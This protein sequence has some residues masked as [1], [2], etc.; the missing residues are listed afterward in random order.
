MAFKHRTEQG[1]HWYEFA[2]HHGVLVIHHELHHDLQRSPLPLQRGGNHHQRLHQGRAEGVELLELFNGAFAGKENVA[3]G[4]GF[5][6]YFL[7]C[8]FDLQAGSL[9]LW[10]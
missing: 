1:T 4:L 7:E 8:L 6:L 5:A 2:E 9:V 3:N 10:A